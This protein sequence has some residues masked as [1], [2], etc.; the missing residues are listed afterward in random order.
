MLKGMWIV[1]STQHLVLACEYPL[2]TVKTS[3]PFYIS[4]LV[5]LDFSFKQSVLDKY[6]IMQNAKQNLFNK[7]S[8]FTFIPSKMI[9]LFFN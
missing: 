6:S 7:V 4:Y 9:C 3:S 1:K 2:L 8:E 5:Y